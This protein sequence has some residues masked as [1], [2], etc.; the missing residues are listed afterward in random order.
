MKTFLMCLAQH[1]SWSGFSNASE[2]EHA[3]NNEEIISTRPAKL[4]V[5]EG[6]GYYQK[7]QQHT[8]EKKQTNSVHKRN[9]WEKGPKE[10]Y[11][12]SGEGSNR[13][14]CMFLDWSLLHRKY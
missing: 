12:K 5:Q 10:G 13:E 4:T 9:K 7:Y 2:K 11:G 8:R 14:D 6:T 3:E 1:W